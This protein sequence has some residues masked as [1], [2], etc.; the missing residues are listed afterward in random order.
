MIGELNRQL[1]DLEA[2]V[3][4]RLSNTRTPTSASLPGLGDVVRVRVLGEFRDDLPTLR[5]PPS[6]A[7]TTPAPHR[8][9]SPPATNTPRQPVTSATGGS[10][11]AID[12]WP[13]SHCPPALDAEP[14]Y[15][16]RRAAGDLHHQAL[17]ALGNRP[18]GILHGCLHHRTTTSTPLGRTVTPPTTTPLLDGL[19]P[20]GV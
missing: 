20:W 18:V 10:Y 9:P 8:P 1:A 4:D 14:V 5:P 15:D 7:R 17:R 11:D 6:L 12:Q 16:Q 3:A 13:S 2:A 19:L